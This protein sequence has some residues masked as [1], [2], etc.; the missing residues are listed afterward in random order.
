[1]AEKMLT[2]GRLAKQT[3]CNI[4]TIRYYE[5][6]GLLADPPRSPGGRR[7]YAQTHVQR[8]VFVRRSRELGFT[9]A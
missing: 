5:R 7:L 1:M 2:I 8:L 3:D 6:I 9:L 4:E